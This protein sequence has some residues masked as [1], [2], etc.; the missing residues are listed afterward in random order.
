MSTQRCLLLLALLLPTGVCAEDLKI[1]F[2]VGCFWHIQHVFIEAERAQLKRSGVTLTSLVGYAGATA[3]GQACYFESKVTSEVVGMTI[4]KTSLHDFATVYFKT[5]AGYDRSHRNDVGPHY[6]AAIG[7]PGG[8]TSPLMAE[9]RRA[10]TDQKSSFTF[11]FAEGK[12]DDADTLNKPLI[13]VYDSIKF[14]FHQAEIYHQFHDDYYPVVGDYPVSY[15][16]LRAKL[17]CHGTLKPT[18]C[19]SDHSQVMS[20]YLVCEKFATATESS[21]LS[22]RPSCLMGHAAVWGG[23]R[24]APA[25]PLVPIGNGKAGGSAALPAPAS[26]PKAGGSGAVPAPAP[27]AK[28]GDAK[29]SGGQMKNAADADA[30]PAKPADGG[31]MKNLPPRGGSGA[32]SGDLHEKKAAASSDTKKTTGV[33]SSSVRVLAGPVLLISGLLC[34]AL[35]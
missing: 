2:G 4:P 1:Y 20:K 26:A 18:G 24:S 13:W 11:N 22:N 16:M 35:L 25:G 8:L 31:Q 23:G 17:T 33:S 32:L 5:F 14:P 9:I 30:K 6:R 28:A 19:G 3:Q 29:G 10:H 15:E 7:L 27:A 12:G 34:K 21:C